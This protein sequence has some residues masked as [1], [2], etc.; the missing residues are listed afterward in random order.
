MQIRIGFGTVFPPDKT[1][2]TYPISEVVKDEYLADYNKQA[3]LIVRNSLFL[4]GCYRL[5]ASQDR[6][7]TTA[8]QR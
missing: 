8:Q 6:G 7:K 4:Y 2:Y 3:G 1:G 5:H